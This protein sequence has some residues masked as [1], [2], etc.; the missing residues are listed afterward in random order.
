MKITIC[1]SIAFL[2]KMM[3]VQKELEE[4]GHEVKTPP[5]HIQGIDGEWFLATDFYKIRKQASADDKRVW[6]EKE[7]AIQNHFDKVVWSDVILVLNEDKNDIPG[8]VGANTLMEM[9]LA[10]HLDKPIYLMQD[11][12]MMSYSEEILAMKPKV[13]NGE[14]TSI[15]EM[16]TA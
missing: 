14:L 15:Q 12:P 1:G 16:M 2:E 4:M 10:F 13:L 8:Y 9:G 3:E 6:D 7:K 11:V 5:M